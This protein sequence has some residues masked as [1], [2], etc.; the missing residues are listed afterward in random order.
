MSYISGRY[1]LLS[2]RV[3]ACPLLPQQGLAVS[4]FNNKEMQEKDVDFFIWI[5]TSAYLFC[6]SGR[7]SLFPV[8]VH[9]NGSRFL[10]Y[11]EMKLSVAVPTQSI[12][13]VLVLSLPEKGKPSKA[14]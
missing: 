11:K 2:T 14:K 6:Q 8:E 5:R 12:K 9:A 10:K 1:G 4:S 13:R 3:L 7:N